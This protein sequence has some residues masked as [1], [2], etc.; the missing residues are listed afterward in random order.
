MTVR[1]QRMSRGSRRRSMRQ[2]LITLGR[3]IGVVTKPPKSPKK[4]SA[5]KENS[6]VVRLRQHGEIN[7]VLQSGDVYPPRLAKLVSSAFKSYLQF[8]GASGLVQAS[9]CT[10]KVVETLDK[11]GF[12]VPLRSS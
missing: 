4:N 8:A 11:V 7:D 2:L 12:S 5:M 3:R 9:N 10:G 6:N 1:E